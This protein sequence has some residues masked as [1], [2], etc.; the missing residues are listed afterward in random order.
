MKLNLF[1]KA[2]GLGLSFHDVRLS[3]REGLFG[4]V[5]ECVDVTLDE[6][7]DI[8]ASILLYYGDMIV[9][10]MFALN[11]YLYLVLE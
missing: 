9:I 6:C 5:I 3:I 2:F 1:F 10:G 4:E 7:G 11:D 8:E